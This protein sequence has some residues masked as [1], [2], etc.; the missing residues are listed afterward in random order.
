MW[1]ILGWYWFSGENPDITAFVLY[2][3][4]V[5]GMLDEFALG[6]VIAR[7]VIDGISGRGQHISASDLMYKLRK[8]HF[9]L[10]GLAILTAGSTWHIL[11]AHA[12]DYWH[13][14]NM[15]VFWRSL[16]ALTAALLII[17][18]IVVQI[19]R[20]LERLL[21]PV[22]YLGR[23]SFGIYLWHYPLIILLKEHGVTEPLSFSMLVISGAITLA[24]LSYHFFER[25]LQTKWR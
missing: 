17:W 11:N 23:I 3:L 22:R 19:P 4:Q 7:W 2:T 21:S 20:W 6:F 10:L 15:V 24:I 16:V 18:M 13:Q 1:R 5:P 25:P 9:V 8:Y 12:S 14:P